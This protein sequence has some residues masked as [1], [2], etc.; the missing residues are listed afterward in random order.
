MPLLIVEGRKYRL[1]NLTGEDPLWNVSVDEKTVAL[2]VLRQPSAQLPTLFVQAGGR[3]ISLSLQGQR[4][5][6]VYFVEVNGRPMT[7]IL[8]EDTPSGQTVEPRIS[9]GPVLVNSPMAGKIALVK[10]SI[11]S[12]VEE[13]QSL[14]ILEAMKMENEISSPKSGTLKELYVK[15]GDLVKAGDRL[16]LVI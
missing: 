3:V 11:D 10:A 14:M 6:R 9:N 2:E 5:Q 13:G 16:C 15:H 7:I 12:K 4:D 1:G 8:E